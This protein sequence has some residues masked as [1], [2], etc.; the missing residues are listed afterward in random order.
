V[1]DFHALAI[2]GNLLIFAVACGTVFLAGTKL[3]RYAEMIS[4]RSGVGAVFLGMV[5]LGGV[6]SLP[7][8]STTVSAAAIGNAALAVN[9]ILGAVMLQVS[10]LALADAF[11]RSRAL[12]V[13]PGSPAVLLQGAL[14]VLV[15]AF[16]AA[17]ILLGDPLDLR[18]GVWTAGIF[19]ITM[20][21]LYLIHRYER[22]PNWQPIMRQAH[23]MDEE[24]SEA[25]DRTPEA[26]GSADRTT[27]KKGALSLAGLVLRTVGAAMVI[28]VAGFALARV[29]DAL[30]A[31][32]GLGSN[33]IGVALVSISTSLPE[34]STTLAAVRLGQFNMAFGN[35]FGSNLVNVGLLLFIDVAYRGGPVLDEV[36]RFSLLAS[37]LGIIVTT[38]YL[39]GLIERGNRRLGRMG[40][41]SIAVLLVYFAGL[42]ALYA[43]RGQ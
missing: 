22:S 17:G 13:V 40:L 20:T 35:I 24:A 41:D 2:W 28:F 38:I 16:V 7:E 27:A 36:G 25:G 15:L 39:V 30:A 4:E 5:L 14:L 23:R 33:F 43:L 6:T 3:A 18:V 42:Y 9:N 10:V 12:T 19:A 29:G 21:A 31:Q 32:T 37:I 26:P 1:P 11:V 34:I 8:L